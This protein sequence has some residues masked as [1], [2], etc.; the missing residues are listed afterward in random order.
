MIAKKRILSWNQKFD[1]EID[2]DESLHYM[3]FPNL[4][5]FS[6]LIQILV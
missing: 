1:G 2:N 6:L 5:L 4:N 3:F